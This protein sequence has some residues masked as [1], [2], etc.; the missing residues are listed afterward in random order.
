V[1]QIPP[2]SSVLY[3]LSTPGSMKLACVKIMTLEA[4]IYMTMST[5]RGEHESKRLTIQ[6][7]VEMGAANQIVG[8]PI[9]NRPM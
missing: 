1:P 5:S 7:N 8:I 2:S 6:K 9:T 3:S 4:P